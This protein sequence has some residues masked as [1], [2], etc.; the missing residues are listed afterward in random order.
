MDVPPIGVSKKCCYM[1]HLLWNKLFENGDET[2]SGNKYMKTHGY[3]VPW[4]PPQFG[5]P[6]SVM[7]ELADKLVNEAARHAEVEAKVL[8]NASQQSS[9]ESIL[10]SLDEVDE[11][12]SQL[13]HGDTKL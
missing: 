2:A 11:E 3:I 1:C 7:Q 6:D 5:I 13:L 4:D 8:R 10:S 12:M 9:P